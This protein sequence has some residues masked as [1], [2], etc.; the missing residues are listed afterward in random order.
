MAK[1]KPKAKDRHA[2][3]FLL[4]LPEVWRDVFR[5]AKEKNRRPFTQEA[6]IALEAHFKEQG[7][8]PPG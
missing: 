1:S 3:A 7:L 2:S 6:I 5:K 8:W 4:R